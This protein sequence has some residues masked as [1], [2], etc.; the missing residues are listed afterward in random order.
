MKYVAIVLLS[1]GIV[2]LSG[3]CVIMCMDILS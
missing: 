1:I 2:V 3:L